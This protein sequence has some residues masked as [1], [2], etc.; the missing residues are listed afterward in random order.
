MRQE[1]YTTGQLQDLMENYLEN[2]AFTGFPEVLFESTNHIMRMKGK[3]IRPVMMLTACQAFGGNLKLAL[4][5]ASAI[6]VYHNFS[7][8]H[9]DII[10][11][12]DIRRG[13][14]TV[15]K[16]YGL[17]K[18]I[19]TGDAML[20]HSFVLLKRG[21]ADKLAEM[22]KVFSKA[23]SEVIEG[24]QL[25]V[26]FEDIPEVSKEEYML[27][28]QYKTSVLLA[29][30]FQIGAII[31]NASAEDQKH[32]YNFGLNLGLAFQIKDDYLDTYG[33]EKTF[34][35]KIGGD[36]IQNKKTYLLI[37]ALENSVETDK[38]AIFGLFDETDEEKKINNMISYYDRLNV[39]D[40]TYEAMER[41][42]QKSLESLN[43]I[44]LEPSA[45][46]SLFALA[47]SIY[48]RKH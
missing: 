16:V 26:N 7:L 23:T 48:H 5:P 22:L 13:Q 25:D 10:D 47:E 38:Q 33:D 15:H 37:Q 45:K 46:D 17:N 27:M 42:Y 29:A 31:G 34:G 30:S 32:I 6:E 8:V 41:L 36:I 20:L 14:P 39:K 2:D 3:R 18:A 12:A 1:L 9:D 43:K 35:K 44:S 11:K 28:I 4:G 40:K 21:P 24:E 19:L